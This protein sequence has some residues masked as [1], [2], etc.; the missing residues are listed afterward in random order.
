VDGFG[1]GVA[2][3]PAAA[4]LLGF[5][6]LA[7]PS[8]G[9]T[10]LLAGSGTHRLAP[11]STERPGVAE[12]LGSAER[13][14]VVER[15]GSAERLGVAERLSSAERPGS[16]G[17]TGPTG[18]EAYLAG[19]PRPTAAVVATAGPSG[20][21]WSEPG[22]AYL[23]VR[24]SGR[25]GAVLARRVARPDGGV[26]AHA[27]LIIAA[28]ESWRLGYLA[29]REDPSGQIGPELG[30]GSIRA[31]RWDKPDLLPAALE[32]GLYLVTMPGDDV[33]VLAQELAQYL[34]SAMALGP[35]GECG[36]EVRAQPVDAAAATDE[37]A[38]IVS[39]AKA[40]WAAEFGAVKPIQ[41]WT[42]STDGVLLRGQGIDTVR[43][44]P[45]IKAASEDPRR[46]HVDLAELARWP[47]IYAALL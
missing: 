16:A 33:L 26:I 35:L 25:Q 15:L 23:R 7:D 21:L 19:E 1:L 9:A 28:I 2:R 46:D 6:E 41:G 20:V 3:A 8:A 44:G 22:A 40:L 31:G 12:R 42:G 36:I 27:G 37:Q 43:L 17:E 14:G 34:R 13:L 32:L 39:Q 45:Q 47:P 10:L 5:A 4:A 24:L 18:V 11:G 30:I 29:G 38:P